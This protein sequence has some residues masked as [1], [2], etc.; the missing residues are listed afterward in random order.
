MASTTPLKSSIASLS[1]TLKARLRAGD[2]LYGLFFLSFSPTLAE[3]AGHAGY[4]FVVVDMEH[5]HGGISDALPCLRALAAAQTPAILRLPENSP[6]W[7]K[8][9]LDLGPQ[10]I[11]F[12]MI[13]GVDSAKKAIAACRYP[14]AGVRGAAHPVVRAS[15]YGID[16]EYLDR[17]EEELLVMC[18]VETEEGV[19]KVE[20]IAG[21]EGVDCIQMGPLDLSA[22]MGHLRDPG[23]GRVTEVMRAAETAVLE[24]KAKREGGA[25]PYLA[26]FAMAHD[27]P[28]ELK[29]RGYHMVS[30]GV[31]VGIFS[32]A[33]V[34]DVRRFRM[35]I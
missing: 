14:P 18:Q 23:N 19:K 24:M 35:A 34:E 28:V 31:D 9:A 12:P 16:A 5:G 2:T 21:V 3:I 8:K 17:C 20:E 4:D 27:G 6:T 29:R 15:K 25:A 10:G 32:S 22:S 30:G 26:G 13:D 33:A 7:A 1:K 11:M